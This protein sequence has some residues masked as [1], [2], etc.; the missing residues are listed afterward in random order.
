MTHFQGVSEYMNS[1]TERRTLVPWASRVQAFDIRAVRL[2]SLRADEQGLKPPL[3][4]LL[5]FVLWV[6]GRH[7]FSHPPAWL[8]S[9]HCL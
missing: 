1:E 2:R 9:T 4:R 8:S 7:G 6:K 5:A 3:L